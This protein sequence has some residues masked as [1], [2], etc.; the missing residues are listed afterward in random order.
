M[1][2]RTKVR[3]INPATGELLG[4]V[5]VNTVKELTAAVAASRSAQAAW[6]RTSLAERRAH[7]LRMRRFVMDHLDEIAVMISSETGKSRMDALS[8]EV[9]PVATALTFYG[10][11][12]ERV[13]SRRR[14]RPG[15]ILTAN[16]RSY[17]DR[18][19]MGVVGIISPWNYPFAIPMH[20]VAMALMAGNGVILKVASQTLLVGQWIERVV[21]AGDL[22]KG[23][24]SLIN[25]PGSVAGKA[26]VSSGIDKLFF[27][28]SVPVGKELMALAADRLLPISL[29]LGGNDAMIVCADADIPRAVGGALWAGY[30]NSGQ[31]CAAVERIFVEKDVYDLFLAQLTDR[32]M[33]LRQGADTGW[34]ID[35]GSLTTRSQLEKVTSIVQDAIA[36]GALIFK[37]GNSAEGTKGFFHPPVVL[38]DVTP[39]MEA[40]QGEV[41][42]PLVSVM[43]VDSV[44]EAVARTNDSDL[45]LAA[46]VWTRDRAKAHA[47]AARLE[48][49]SVMINDHMMSHGLA[50]TPWG[51]F[52]KSGLGRTHSA[53]G[54]EAMTQPRV[55][56]DDILPF[57]RRDLWWYPHTRTVYEGLKGALQ[58][59]FARPLRARL[60]GALKLGRI[61]PRIFYP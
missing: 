16:K 34:N 24:F 53:I 50:E 56:I 9:F 20:E 36:K 48:V 14:L 60:T 59:L 30:S 41:F 43:K 23:L 46:S 17:I 29:E 37:N 26:F 21:Q 31:S 5:P 15:S 32:V 4:S 22:P 7:L 44:D 3:S 33:K 6:A 8:T 51:G 28:G 42:G 58:L 19:P 25:L 45:G 10:R 13:L 55:V 49:G 39:R 52:K 47:I 61:V 40:M 27:T 12:A 35:I 11:E 1:P 2:S 18:V 57:V 38:A 54:L